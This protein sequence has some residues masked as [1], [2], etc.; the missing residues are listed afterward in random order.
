[1]PVRPPYETA[2]KR[3]TRRWPLWGLGRSEGE[4]GFDH[5]CREQDRGGDRPG[6]GGRTGRTVTQSSN[7]FRVVLKTGFELNRQTR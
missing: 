6:P 5:G 4:E 3:I 1:M 2:E 7:R